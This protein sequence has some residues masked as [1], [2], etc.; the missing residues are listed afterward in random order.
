MCNIYLY[1]KEKF[2]GGPL[3]QSIPYVLFSDFV[4]AKINK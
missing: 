2:G 3:F 4:F 1:L